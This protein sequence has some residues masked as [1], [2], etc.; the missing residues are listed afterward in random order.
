MISSA[1]FT[2]SR[3]GAVGAS[4]PLTALQEGPQPRDAVRQTESC[5]TDLMTAS[6][7]FSC[8]PPGSFMAVSGQ[9]LVSAVSIFD[10]A[11]D[12]RGA[13][14][15]FFVHRWAVHDTAAPHR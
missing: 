4:A 8:P 12:G 13:T 5:R 9:F 7:Q 1:D 10:D 2:V 15:G 11:K 3:L 6:G 14:G